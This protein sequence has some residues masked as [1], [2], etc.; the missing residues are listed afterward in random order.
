MSEKPTNPM[1]GK[2]D[3]VVDAL[4]KA[5]PPKEA[6]QEPKAERHPRPARERENG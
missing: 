3:E 6:H 4:A 2:F 1:Y 5:P